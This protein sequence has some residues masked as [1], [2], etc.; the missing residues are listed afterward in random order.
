MPGCSAIVVDHPLI[1]GTTYSARVMRAWVAGII[2]IPAADLLD[3]RDR[4]PLVGWAGMGH[5]LPRSGV[6]LT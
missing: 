3:D 6:G 4:N 5:P 2:A 1:M